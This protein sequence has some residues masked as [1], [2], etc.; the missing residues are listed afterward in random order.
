[1]NRIPR[2]GPLHAEIRIQAKSVPVGAFNYPGGVVIFMEGP[3]KIDIFRL[4][5]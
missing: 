5:L 1:M 4:G 3:V 2:P